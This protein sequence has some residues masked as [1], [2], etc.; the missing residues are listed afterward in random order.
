MT[1][2]MTFLTRNSNC[3]TQGPLRPGPAVPGRNPASCQFQP[4]L[5]GGLGSLLSVAP[6]HLPKHG[7]PPKAAWCTQAH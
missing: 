6:L 7:C 5:G 2:F 1:R 4:L 3:Q